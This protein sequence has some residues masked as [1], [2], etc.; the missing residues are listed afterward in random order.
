MSP[1]TVADLI[2]LLQTFPQGLPVAYRLHSEQTLME[3][4][5]IR[6]AN[7]SSARV[8]GWIQDARPDI[9]KCDYLLFPGN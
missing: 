2:A 9:P 8:D 3:P 4:E 6:I 7:L 1:M 5:D